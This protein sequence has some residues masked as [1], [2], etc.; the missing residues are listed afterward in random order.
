M[1]STPRLQRRSTGRT[2]GGR[3]LSTP[4]KIKGVE[5]GTEAEKKTAK[6][7]VCQQ[8]WAYEVYQDCKDIFTAHDKYFSHLVVLHAAPDHL[9]RELAERMVDEQCRQSSKS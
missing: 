2:A 3:S 7:Q 6:V 8:I 1:G 5:Q 4:P 9:W